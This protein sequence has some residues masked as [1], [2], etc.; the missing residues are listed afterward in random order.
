M[1]ANELKGRAVVTLSDAAKV[2]QI[3]DVLFDADYR[4]V[5]GFR[6]KKGTFSRADAVSRAS[7]TAVGSDAVTVVG[8]DA[9]N[10]ADRLEDLIGAMDLGQAEKTKVVTEGGNL[11]GTV[12]ELELDDDASYVNAYILSAPLWDRLRNREPRIPAHQVLRLG[13]GG[14]MIVPNGVADNLRSPQGEKAE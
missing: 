8:P 2:G 6:V 4:K 12:A 10:T 1:K 5:L 7:V 9:I 13:E 3:D 14:I 11:I